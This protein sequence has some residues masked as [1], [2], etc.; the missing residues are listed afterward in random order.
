MKK[1]ILL[2][3]TILM[4]IVLL[5]SAT[6]SVSADTATVGIC[7]DKARWSFDQSTGT[8]TISG[9]GAMSDFSSLGGPWDSHRDFIKIVVINEGITGIGDCAFISCNNLTNVTIGDSVTSIGYEAFSDCTSL[10]SVMIPD[11]VTSIGYAAFSRCYSLTNITVDKGNTVYHSS[12][13]CIIETASKTLITGCK[14]SVIPTDGSVTIIDVYAFDGCSS[15][16]SIDI[17][18][19]V[20]SIGT[21]AFSD[22]TSLVSITIPDSVTSIGMVAFSDCTSLTN[23]TI[24]DGVTKIFRST[25]ENCASLTSITIPDKITSIGDWAFSRCSSLASI[26]I[27]DNVT[28]IGYAAFEG[29][30]S[31]T[32]ITIPDSVTSIGRAAFSDCTGLTNITLPFVNIFS[33][34]FG[35]TV[36]TSLTK[37]TITCEKMIGNQ[38]FKDCTNIKQIIISNTTQFIGSKAFQNCKNL[39]RI[40]IPKSIETI[41]SQIFEGCENLTYVLCESESK[42]ESWQSDWNGDVA[43]VW[44]AQ[45]IEDLPLDNLD[46]NLLQITINQ[47]PLYTGDEVLPDI[48]VSY[49]NIPLKNKVDY[50]IVGSNNIDA[51][52][53]ASL[54]VYG[55][56]KYEGISKNIKYEIQKAPILECEVIVSDQYYTGTT[57]S[58]LVTVKKGNTKLVQNVDFSVLCYGNN[59]IGTVA[60]EIV[61]IGNYRGT[62]RKTFEIKEPPI[63]ESLDVSF[64]SD[65]DSVFY[66]NSGDSVF[67][68]NELSTSSDTTIQ[69]T[70]SQNKEVIYSNTSKN[71]VYAFKERGEYTV[72]L[73]LTTT[74]YKYDYEYVNGV[75][76]LVKKEIKHHSD[77]KA[78]INVILKNNSQPSSLIANPPLEI[79]YKHALLSVECEDPLI[80]IAPPVWSSSNSDVISVDQ[81]GKITYNKPGVAT[82]TAQVGDLQATWEIENMTLDLTYGYIVEYDHKTKKASVYFDNDYLIEG[83]DYLVSVVQ[84]ENGIVRITVEGC[85]LFSGSLTQAYAPDADYIYLCEHTYD[86]WSSENSDK[87]RRICAICGDIHTENHIYG[88]WTK[89]DDTHH[90]KE[91]ACGE[92]QIVNH[93][94]NNGESTTPA[95][96]LTTGIKTFTCTDCGETKTESIDKLPDH[97]YGEWEKHDDKQHKKSCECGDIVYTD[98][99]W[100]DGD[101][102]EKPTHT[103]KGVKK[104][105]CT[106]CGETKTETLD[107]LPDHIYGE[108]EKHDDKQ[109]KKSCECGDIVYTDH[110]WNDG[111]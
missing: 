77:Y 82:I 30:S 42:P 64:S 41:G 55:I 56:G 61:G 10:T 28:S 37:V 110:V 59:E 36:P 48:T 43:V 87:H 49:N 40:L 95:T 3:T 102:T 2:L 31:L 99:V 76:R 1:T 24:P 21:A 73:R 88:E 15:I 90:Q 14:N 9:T 12:G 85:N 13:N 4:L 69:W 74:S 47:I 93:E 53:D 17:P 27:P 91:C 71:I 29:C 62:I 35:G 50:V 19:S 72:Q 83:Q 8:L 101:I 75:M 67:F 45:L 106:D 20:T 81:N 60:V 109:H 70:I 34:F 78:T 79:D 51:T 97:I 16:K 7:G 68:W 94:W 103:S 39:S 89:N 38:A 46:E 22:C 6:V 66:I 86:N 107:K 52:R 104:I 44:G 111:D 108:W 80:N 100:N 18:D 23:I 26:T 98:H 25:F 54:Y 84:Y 96:H 92:I 11:S 57:I 32:N 33:S 63:S 105:T 65:N 5:L 58:P